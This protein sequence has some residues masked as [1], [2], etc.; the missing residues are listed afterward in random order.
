[1]ANEL[2]SYDLN[3]AANLLNVS[4]KIMYQRC[5]AGDIRWYRVGTQIRITHE[6]LAEY[7]EEQERQAAAESESI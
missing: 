2:Q 4:A 7:I 6:A 3:E 5:Q 1:M